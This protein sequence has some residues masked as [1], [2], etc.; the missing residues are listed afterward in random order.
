MAE[1][2][3]LKQACLDLSNAALALFDAF[4]RDG[5]EAMWVQDNADG[6]RAVMAMQ[7][8]HNTLADFLRG[9]S[10]RRMLALGVSPE[11]LLKLGE[12]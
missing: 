4:E 6:L 2:G 10:V 5:Y 11:A 8:A 7:N 12:R 3:D 9:Q 1:L